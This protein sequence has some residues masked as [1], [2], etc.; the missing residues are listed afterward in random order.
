[1]SHS[2]NPY[3][4]VNAHL[5]SLLQ[6]PDTFDEPSMW[7]SFHSRHITYIAD[8]L[9]SHLP[10]HY[11]AFS[12]QSLQ[13]ENF[14][15]GGIRSVTSPKPDVAIFHR[16]GTASPGV[17]FV[18]VTTTWEAPVVEV[19]EPIKQPKAVVIRELLPQHKLG[20]IGA[21]IELLSPSNKPGGSSHE[22]YAV[23]RFHALENHIPLIEIDYLHES[24]SIVPQVPLYPTA[25]DAY[26][27]WIT[28]TDPRPDWK[29]GKAQGYGFRVDEPIKKF[30]LPPAG[31]EKIVFDLNPVYQHTFWAGRWSDL[32]DYAV[33][34]ERFQ[35]YSP[36]DQAFIR[37]IMLKIGV[38]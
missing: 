21:R 8:D 18:E 17:Y 29:L 6:T 26:P 1:M 31:E 34:P 36:S 3:P 9:N 15:F 37:Q 16:S 4:G 35:T 28:V 12:E 14:D 38:S 2:P 13:I 33:E 25:S 10:S 19:V 24:R 11:I 7:P 5:N 22:A 32:L 30:V 20:Q 23:N 27:Y